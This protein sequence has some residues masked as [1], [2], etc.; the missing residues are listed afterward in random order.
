MDKYIM[1][2]IIAFGFSIASMFPAGADVPFTTG[3]WVDFALEKL[4]VNGLT[5]P[6]HASNRPFDRDEMTAAV[7]ELL[8]TG[9]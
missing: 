2:T 9:S 1:L 5:G 4:E 6:V 8:A 7:K 3:E